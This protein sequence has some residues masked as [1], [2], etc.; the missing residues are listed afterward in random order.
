MYIHVSSP[1]V[2]K[3][4]G[5]P[6]AGIWSPWEGSLSAPGAWALSLWLNRHLSGAALRGHCWVRSIGP[7]GAAPRRRH[8]AMLWLWKPAATHEEPENDR[9]RRDV[10][11]LA[12]QLAPHSSAQTGEGT[13]EDASGP[14]PEKCS[15][16]AR[17][18]RLPARPAPLRSPGAWAPVPRGSSLRPPRAS[19]PRAD[20]G[21]GAQNPGSGA[22]LGD[23]E[24]LPRLLKPVFNPPGKRDRRCRPR[25]RWIPFPFPLFYLLSSL[26]Y[27]VT[28]DPVF[29][30]DFVSPISRNP[31]SF[32]LS[33]LFSPPPLFPPQCLLL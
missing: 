20:R 13:S 24:Q 29:S 16:L 30:L 8:P 3:H 14:R 17:Q 4:P 2:S 33:L 1:E 28:F 9:E 32:L 23:L 10:A 22:R 12:F 7:G 26:A 19:L 18:W 5:S 11:P 6:L 21:C 15:C 25:L 27:A 31:F